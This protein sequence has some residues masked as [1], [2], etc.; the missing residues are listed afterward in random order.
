MTL[1][2]YHFF[3]LIDDAVHS[4][5]RA[6]NGRRAV[7]NVME[8]DDNALPLQNLANRTIPLGLQVRE[9]IALPARLFVRAREVGE[10][11][12]HR[13]MRKSRDPCDCRHG[14]GDF[15]VAVGGK[16]DAVHAGIERDMGTDGHTRRRGF[17]L[18][19]RGIV[20]GQE[21]LG[22]G[23]ATQLERQFGRGI[24]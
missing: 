6:P 4:V 11:S 8:R 19:S 23:I 18:Q 3:L 1:Y 13:Q 10:H 15:H 7:A 9:R 21:R 22:D 17:A 24:F 16:A 5:R 2:F 20:L 12:L 14:C